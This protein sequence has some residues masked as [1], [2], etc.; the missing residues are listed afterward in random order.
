MLPRDERYTVDEIRPLVVTSLWRLVHRDGQLL[1][2]DVSERCICHKLGQYIEWM[3][4]GFDTDCEYN[5]DG[6][7]DTKVIDKLK[8]MGVANWLSPDI[9]VHR[10]WTDF[11]KF[12]I[13][14]KKTTNTKPEDRSDDLIKLKAF[15]EGSMMSSGRMCKY[16]VGLFLDIATGLQIKEF[17]FHGTWYV[18]GNAVKEETICRHSIPDKIRPH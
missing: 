15:T 4:P 6:H 14:A 11:N 1:L 9:I 13:Q 17:S 8:A 12:I 10:R 16:D 5:N 3:F 2:G 7:S 18:D